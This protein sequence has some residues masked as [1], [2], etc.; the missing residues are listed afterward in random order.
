MGL[1]SMLLGG[2]GGGSRSANEAWRCDKTALHS[3]SSKSGLSS[4]FPSPWSAWLFP[5]NPYIAFPPC[6]AFHKQPGSSHCISTSVKWFGQALSI[7]HSLS[8]SLSPS[9]SLSLFSY[10]LPRG[11]TAAVSCLVV[12][13]SGGTNKASGNG[14][15]SQCTKHTKH[16]E[17]RSVQECSQEG[18]EAVQKKCCPRVICLHLGMATQWRPHCG[19]PASHSGVPE[20]THP[21]AALAMYGCFGLGWASARRYRR[22]WVHR[23]IIR[24]LQWQSNPFQS[25]S[26]GDA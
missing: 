8:L 20:M 9:H 1:G 2:G 11:L 24:V 14:A 7:S 17:Q 26:L 19:G 10:F 22:Q 23:S 15:A 18:G 25:G 6:I 5:S 12:A 3:L 13:G 21:W 16:R 4:S